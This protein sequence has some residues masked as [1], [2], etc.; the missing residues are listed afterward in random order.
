MTQSNLIARGFSLAFVAIAALTA[1]SMAFA[2]SAS[3]F[4]G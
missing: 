3:L 1:L 2:P 4:A